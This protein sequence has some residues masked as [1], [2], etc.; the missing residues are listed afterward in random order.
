MFERYLEEARRA[1]FYARMVTML[2]GAPKIDSTHLLSGVMW[3]KDF[4]ARTLFGLQEIFP[5]YT[6]RPHLFVESEALKKVEGPQL[7]NDSKKILARAA[8][9]ADALRDYWIGTEHLL[10]GILAESNCT[11]ARNLAKANISLESARGV[12][13]EN[14]ATRPKYPDYYGPPKR[15]GEMPSLWDKM[16][17]KWRK[18]K[19]RARG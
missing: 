5:V 17:S 19:Y 7:T 18:W 3:E 11:A 14:A 4:R 12:I 16:I 9:E 13:R 1:I 8:M 15:E 2:S 6:G 10:L